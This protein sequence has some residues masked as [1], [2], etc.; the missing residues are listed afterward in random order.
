MF[1][2]AVYSN[3][4]SIIDK[5]GGITS[6]MAPKKKDIAIKNISG[7]NLKGLLRKLE[8]TMNDGTLREIPLI[9]GKNSEKVREIVMGL[10]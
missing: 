8:I 4:I 5:R 7:V 2:F 10:I 1:N 3:R 9:F 6:Y